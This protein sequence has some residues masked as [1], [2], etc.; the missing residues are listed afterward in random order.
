VFKDGL[1]KKK[2]FFWTKE[3]VF[4]EEPAIPLNEKAS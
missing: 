1:N 2:G 3:G 4:V